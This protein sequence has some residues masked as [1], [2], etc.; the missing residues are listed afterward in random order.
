MRIF[1]MNMWER[2]R[3]MIDFLRNGL[4]CDGYTVIVSTPRT[5]KSRFFKNLFYWHRTRRPRPPGPGEIIWSRFTFEATHCSL[6]A[7]GGTVI[8]IIPAM[9]AT[10]FTKSHKIYGTKRAQG[11]KYGKILVK[12]LLAFGM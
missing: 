5:S 8:Y 9:V 1:H 12:P 2:I 10:I 3:C 4:A 6:E 7:R 11:L